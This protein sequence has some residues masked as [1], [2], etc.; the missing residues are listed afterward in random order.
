MCDTKVPLTDAAGQYLD[1]PGQQAICN[2]LHERFDYPTISDPPLT[3]AEACDDCTFT[4]RGIAYWMLY[5]AVEEP[6]ELIARTV[7]T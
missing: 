7:I 1:E 5:G 3:P 6:L 4:R 2:V